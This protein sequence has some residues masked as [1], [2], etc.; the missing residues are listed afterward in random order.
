MVAPADPLPDGRMPGPVHP[1]LFTNMRY[2]AELTRAG[3]DALGLRTIVPEHVQALDSSDHIRE[4]RDVG[5]AVA[6]RKVTAGHLAGV[7]ALTST[8]SRLEVRSCPTAH[9]RHHR[10][11]RRSG[12][13]RPS[14][15]LALLSDG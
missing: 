11:A 2:N 14:A 9:T 13:A 10:P 1:K 8:R 15:R 3:L 7:R 12:A 4:L 6:A 5:D